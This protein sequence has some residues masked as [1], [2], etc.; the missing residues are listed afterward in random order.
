MQAFSIV[1]KTSKIIINN[2]CEFDSE[3]DL[4]VK[5]VHETNLEGKPATLKRTKQKAFQRAQKGFSLLEIMIVIVIMASLVG[6]VG[7]MLFGRLDDAKIDQAKIQMKLLENS[8]DMYRVHMGGYPTTGQGL[9]ALVEE[10]SSDGPA[11]W[12]GP[13]IKG[14][15]PVDPWGKP[16]DYSSTGSEVQMRTFGA[17]G[18]EGG[19]ENDADIWLE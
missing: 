17:D 8:L 1:Q 19:E 13:Y 14:K 7:P 2:H 16:Y 18:V 15:M 6:L 12:R 9:Q 4:K 11:N 3:L 10:P 5:S